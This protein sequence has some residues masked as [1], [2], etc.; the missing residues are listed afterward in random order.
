MF[1]KHSKEWTN[2]V[3]RGGK[4]FA[5]RIKSCASVSKAYTYNHLQN[6]PRKHVWRQGGRIYECRSEMLVRDLLM[7]D[8]LLHG[9]NFEFFSKVNEDLMTDFIIWLVLCFRYWDTN[10]LVLERS[11]SIRNISKY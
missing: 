8:I 6:D 11:I 10:L 9:K 2:L 3:K 1:I 5:R 4:N 7:K